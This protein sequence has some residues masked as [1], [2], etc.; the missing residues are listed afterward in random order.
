MAKLSGDLLI[1]H[2]I[3]RLREDFERMYPEDR[4]NYQ[5]LTDVLHSHAWKLKEK[6]DVQEKERDNFKAG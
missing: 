5:K 1:L 3:S 4:I 2:L 6:S